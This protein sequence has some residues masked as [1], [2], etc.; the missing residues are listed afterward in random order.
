MS[1]AERLALLK[2]LEENY[3][4][5]AEGDPPD[6]RARCARCQ[7]LMPVNI[8]SFLAVVLT[9]RAR[10]GELICLNCRAYELAKKEEVLD[11]E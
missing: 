10:D 3:A 1:K 9:A 8:S 2:Q 7:A 11:G 5:K 6:E 4:K